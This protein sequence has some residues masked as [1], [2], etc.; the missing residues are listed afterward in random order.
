MSSITCLAEVRLWIGSKGGRLH[1]AFLIWPVV[2][3]HA[4]AAGSRRV[5]HCIRPTGLEPVTLGLEIPCSIQLSYGRVGG[6]RGPGG[7][8]RDGWRGGLENA[9]F[10]YHRRAKQGTSGRLERTPAD[11]GSRVVFVPTG[12]RSLRVRWKPIPGQ[13]GVWEREPGRSS[14]HPQPQCCSC[15]PPHAGRFNRR[16]QSSQRNG[17]NAGAG[18]STPPTAAVLPAHSGPT[19]G[20]S[21][22]ARRSAC[23]ARTSGGTTL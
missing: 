9:P 5:H 17:S 3:R 14:H 13:I 4:V 12:Q 15:R 19:S 16:S 6:F 21:R 11:C 20:G 10:F 23:T 2:V 8:L 18:S 1:R 7:Q 22:I